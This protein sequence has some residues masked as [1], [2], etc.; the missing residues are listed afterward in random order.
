TDWK[1]ILTA[2]PIVA[3]GKIFVLDAMGHVYAYSAETGAGIWNRS[4]APPEEDDPERSYGGGI[5]FDNGRLYVTTGFR[6]AYALNA[7]TGEEIW[8]ITADTPI[9]TAPAVADGRVYV[10]TQENHL[11]VLN[12]DTGVLMWDHRGIAEPAALAVSTN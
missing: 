12:A 11:I 9:H 7:N 10:I 3:D 5:A 1:S 6:H 2:S 4:M 8:N